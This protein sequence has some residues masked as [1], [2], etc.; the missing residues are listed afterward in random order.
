MLIAINYTMTKLIFDID[1]DLNKRFRD[2]IY[3]EKGLNKG[4]IKDALR[5]AIEL[6]IDSK[7]EVKIPSQ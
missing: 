3:H 2:T 5:E 7:L 4:V 1:E 6:W